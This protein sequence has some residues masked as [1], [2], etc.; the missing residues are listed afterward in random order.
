MPRQGRQPAQLTQDS[1]RGKAGASVKGG[2]NSKHTANAA[3]SAVKEQQPQ[4]KKQKKAQRKS[5]GAG[6]SGGAGAGDDDDEQDAA[7]DVYNYAA[8]IK[9][10]RGDVDPLARASAGKSSK[11]KGK[12]R[13]PVATGGDDEDDDDDEDLSDDAGS[14][15]S[16]DADGFHVRGNQ[17]V[18]FTGRKPAGFKLGLD[19]GD[20]GPFVGSDDEDEEIDSDF[21]SDEDDEEDLPAPKR[22]SSS[23]AK[24]KSKGKAR[25]AEVDLD[26]DEI[27]YDDEEGEGWMDLADVLDAGGYGTPDDE[28]EDGSS[29]GGSDDSEAEE[30]EEM[31]SASDFDPEDPDALSRLDSF[32]EGLDSKKR[33]TRGD[34]ADESGASKK[35]RAVLKERTEAY[36]EGEF[37]AVKPLDG[38]ADGEEA[39]NSRCPRNGTDM[40]PAS[41][42]QSRLGRLA[43]LLYRLEE[44]AARLPPQ[45]AQ[46]ARPDRLRL[47][48]V[49]QSHDDQLAL[50]GGRSAR[51]SA[52]RPLAG[53]GRPRGGV[54]GDQGRDGQVERDGPAHEGRKRHRRRWRAPRALDA[55]ACRWRR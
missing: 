40:S 1:K 19:S 12:A 16:A 14:A 42:R 5:V 7:L 24:D 45:V 9:R 52:P 55:A 48:R 27:D 41:C 8:R 15:G 54:R 36:P 23:T 34:D 32:V 21:V 43:V 4:S 18:D 53:Q 39:P 46:A 49:L 38:S 13:A 30:D 44:P 3:I 35:K 22:A 28:D 33:K 2:A 37:T 17:V 6:T 25:Q 31:S 29:G 51:R 10:P 50:E 20:E 26:E 47:G 11:G